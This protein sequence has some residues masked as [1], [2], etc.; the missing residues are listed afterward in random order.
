MLK[1]GDLFRLPISRKAMAQKY[2]LGQLVR[3]L[4]VGLSKH[5]AS[6]N[7]LYEVIRVMPADQTGDIGYRIKSLSAGERAVGELQISAYVSPE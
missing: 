2:H 3:L 5:D 7:D 4:R 1:E 6:A